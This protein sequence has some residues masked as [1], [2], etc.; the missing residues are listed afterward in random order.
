MRE[1]VRVLGEEGERGV[2][3]R[4][5]RLWVVLL[6]AGQSVAHIVGCVWELFIEL[7]GTL[8]RGQRYEMIDNTT[9]QVPN[10]NRPV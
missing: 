6:V 8:R 3:R 7:S 4:G 9:D 5:V 2:D 1:R 10:D